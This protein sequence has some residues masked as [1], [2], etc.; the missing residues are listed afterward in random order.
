[1]SGTQFRIELDDAAAQRMFASLHA[2]AT[3]GALPLF[4]EIGSALEASTRERIESTKRA[5]DGTPWLPISEAWI[6]HKRGKGYAEGIL[7]MRGDLLNSVAFEAAPNYVDVIAGPTDYAA[8]HQY[9]GQAGRGHATEIPARPYM[10]VS[11]E[12]ADEIREATEAWLA[13]LAGGL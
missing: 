12:D 9:G 6:E 7:T 2:G 4:T 1:M 8:I 13:R 11:E 5:P 3:S 10:G